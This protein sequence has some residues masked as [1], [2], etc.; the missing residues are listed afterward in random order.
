MPGAQ[1]NAQLTVGQ[2][3]FYDCNYPGTRVE[4]G[5]TVLTNPTLKVPTKKK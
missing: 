4:Y 5:A 3:T 2:T 1:Q